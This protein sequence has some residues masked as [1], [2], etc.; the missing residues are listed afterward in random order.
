[1][2]LKYGKDKF[3]LDKDRLNESKVLLPNE[4]AGLDNPKQEVAKALNNPIASD[5]LADLVEKKNPNTVVIVVNDVSRTTPY[6]EMLPPL[7]DELHQAGVK[8]EEITFIIAT[9]IH[10][11]NTREEN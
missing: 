1:M 4:Q 2:K 7:L 8:K 3:K 9:G 10:R 11:P 6:A 5:S